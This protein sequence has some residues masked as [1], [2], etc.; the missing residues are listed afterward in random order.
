MKDSGNLLS[1]K[2]T[3][4]TSKKMNLRACFMGLQKQMEASLS[5][6]RESISHPGAKGDA[7]E[8]EWLTMLQ[9]YLPRRYQ[10]SKSFVIDSTGQISDQIDIVIYDRQ[11]SPFLFNKNNIF[12]VPA[13]SVYA[14]LEVKQNLNKENIEYAGAKAQSVRKLYRTSATIPHAG[15]EYSP[16]KPFN[17]AAGIVTFKSG[18][19]PPLDSK[20]DDVIA[21]LQKDK[22]IDFGCVLKSGAFE[23]EYPKNAKP[24]IKKSDSEE[25]LI[26]FFLTL[27][28][29]LQKLGTVPALDI[30]KYAMSLKSR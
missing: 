14:I 29:L 22:R 27:L 5:T 15:G 10:A 28:S 7:S 9:N 30:Q 11:Y 8:L 4:S 16:K 18:W 19:K 23:I 24:K 21:K 6:E 20:F 13:E 26:S 3:K 25:S 12:Y 17:I 1:N 2:M